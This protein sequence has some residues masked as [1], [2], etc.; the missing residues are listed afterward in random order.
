MAI[1]AVFCLCSKIKLS[2]AIMETSSIFIADNPS[3]VTIPLANV[4]AVIAYLVFW[5]VSA[6]YLYSEGTKVVKAHNYPFGSFSHPP[7][8]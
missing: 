7:M 6:I 3:S 4:A 5:V 2:I 8:V 1:I